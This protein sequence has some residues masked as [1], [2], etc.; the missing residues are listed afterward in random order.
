MSN[1][2]KDLRDVFSGKFADFRKSINGSQIDEINQLRYQA[3]EAFTENGFPQTRD[4]EYKYTPITRTLLKSVNFLADYPTEATVVPPFSEHLLPGL[5]GYTLVFWNGRLVFNSGDATD[6]LSV[7]PF[8]Q[9]NTGQQNRLA[10]YLGKLINSKTDTFAA[11]NTALLNQGCAITVKPGANSELPVMI[12]HLSDGSRGAAYSQ[13]R[14]LI[15]VGKNSRATVVEIFKNLSEEPQS[16]HNTATEVFVEENASLTLYKI[17]TDCVGSILVDNTHIDQKRHSQLFCNTITTTG[18]MIRNNLNIN[19]NGEYC[20][21]HMNGLYLLN[22]NSHVDNH[23]LVDHRIANSF[24]NEM[25]KGIVDDSATGVFNG[26]I[27]VQPDAQK[28]NAFQSNKNILLSDKARMN[29]K[30]QLE[31]WADDVKCSHG[32]TTGQLDAD[33]VFYLRSRGLD[34]QQARGLLLYA[35]ATEFLDNISLSVLHEYLEKVIADRLYHQK[36]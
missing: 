22:K 36:S 21:S 7:E 5:K 13:S 17:Q 9:L 4:E 27:Y 35:F 30:P 14:N 31:I 29:T 34:K 15:L 33:Q 3:M 16:F 32:A 24:S 8:N 25:Y 2:E 23:T 10:R 6:E 12:Y 1:T 18:K 19:I 26:K 20:E 28:T 11:L